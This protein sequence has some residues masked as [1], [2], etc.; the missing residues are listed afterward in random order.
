[1]GTKKYQNR[2]S[3]IRCPKDDEHPFNRVPASLY[4][5]DGYQF[6]IMAQILSNR[7]DWNIVQKEIRQR[8]K[9]PRQKFDQAWNS[10]VEMGYIQTKQIQGGWSYRIIEDPDFTSTTGGDCENLTYT[11]GGHCEGGVLTTT[12]N[13]YYTVNETILSRSCHKKEFQELL[14]ITGL[15]SFL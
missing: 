2:T 11:T 9:F 6:A 10:L 7:D 3:Y 12:N 15:P 4:K 5:L 8:V 14:E 1:M 13:N